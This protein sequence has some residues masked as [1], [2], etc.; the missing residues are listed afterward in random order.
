MYSWDNCEKPDP[1]DE[2]TKHLVVV[3]INPPAGVPEAGIEIIGTFDGWAGTA[4]ERIEE[5]GWYLAILEDIVE[6]GE[7]KFREAGTWE[8]EIVNAESG[9]GLGNIKFKDVWS[10]DT[11]KGDPCKLIEIDYSEGYVWKAN[12]VSP[13]GVEDIVLTVKAQ[14]VVVDGVMYIVRDNKLFNVQGAQ[15]R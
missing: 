13:E 9:E 6:C 2:E 3:G 8:N 14:K 15:I 4:M 10:D 1:C 7:F 11:W 5:T 12:W